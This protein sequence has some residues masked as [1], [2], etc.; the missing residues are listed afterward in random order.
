MIYREG[1]E[2][3]GGGEGGGGGRKQKPTLKSF[4][5]EKAWVSRHSINSPIESLG[6][7]TLVQ[8]KAWFLRGSFSETELTL[9]QKVRI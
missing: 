5:C 2:K 4:T 6:F 1:T 9:E 8:P 3:G 7:L